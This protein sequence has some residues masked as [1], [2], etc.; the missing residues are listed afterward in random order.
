MIT[1]FE[2]I[3]QNIRTETH[4]R[5][6][7]SIWNNET[8]TV[9]IVDTSGFGKTFIMKEVSYDIIRDYIDSLVV[10]GKGKHYRMLK[11]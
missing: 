1:R 11:F 8:G 4:G 9:S 10:N 5:G 6:V 3:I 7:K 2:N